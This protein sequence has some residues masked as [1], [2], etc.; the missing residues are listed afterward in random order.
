[1]GWTSRDFR[2]EKCCDAF[3]AIVA[4]P[5]RD[6]DKHPE[7]CDCGGV[8][9]ATMSAVPAAMTLAVGSEAHEAA[10]EKRARDHD[11]KVTHP[12][13]FGERNQPVARRFR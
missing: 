10:I 1:M 7:R 9:R 2:C 11:R 12:Q 6:G 8:V 13:Y 4:T 3:S 5:C